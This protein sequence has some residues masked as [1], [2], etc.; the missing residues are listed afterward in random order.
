ME[1]GEINR[2]VIIGKIE[3][4][5]KKSEKRVLQRRFSHR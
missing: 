2:E 5:C 1:E 3:N 4:L